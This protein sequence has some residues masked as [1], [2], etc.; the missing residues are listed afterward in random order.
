[1]TH[2]LHDPKT[3][4]APRRRVKQ[5]EPFDPD[6]LSRKL[7][8]HLVEQ[9]LKAQ[10]RHQARAAKA[11]EAEALAAALHAQNVYRHVP[12]VAARDMERT[13]TP[14]G[15]DRKMHKLAEPVVKAHLMRMGVD[16]NKPSQPLTLLQ[17]TIAT[18][19]AILEN[20]LLRNRNQFQWTHDMEEAA[21][22]DEDRD[23]YKPPQR[24]FNGEFAHLMGTHKKGAPRPL[25]TGDMFLEEEGSSPPHQKSKPK[26]KPKPAPHDVVNDHRNDWAQRDGETEQR[27]KERASPFLRKME[28][29]WMLMGKKEKARRDEGIA[30]FRS[31]PPEGRKIKGSFL[32]IFKRHPS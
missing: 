29:S 17:K 3:N 28:S 14:I 13:T 20:H 5:G 6:E 22:A 24:T 1:M 27:K 16:E 2:P 9:K 7:Q 12:A 8:A 21:E 18:D 19:Q 15:K 4:G 23:L 31:S 11:A 10:Q 30:T 32:A 25:S 26:P